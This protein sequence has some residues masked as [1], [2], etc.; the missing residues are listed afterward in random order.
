MKEVIILSFLILYI[1]DVI[2]VKKSPPDFP[3][4]KNNTTQLQ[5]Y[6][7]TRKKYLYYKYSP[8]NVLW[9]SMT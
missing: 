5:N 1:K 2:Q 7:P 3:I 4:G 6:L 9:I 8:K